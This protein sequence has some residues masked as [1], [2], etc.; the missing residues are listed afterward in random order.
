MGCNHPTIVWTNKRLGMAD[1]ASCGVE[2]FVE[3]KKPQPK[4]HWV[5]VCID[6]HG[7]QD[8]ALVR[9]RRRC[10][11]K[12]RHDGPCIVSSPARKQKAHKPFSIARPPRDRETTRFPRQPMRSYPRRALHKIEGK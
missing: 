3:E 5:T 1:C 8:T 9:C 12:D 7:M 2:L 11:L 10:V 6:E 4:L